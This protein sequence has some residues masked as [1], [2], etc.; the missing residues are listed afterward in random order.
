MT[1]A[2]TCFALALTVIAAAPA[3]ARTV[4][5]DIAGGTL[6]QSVAHLGRQ[7]RVSVGLADQVLAVRRVPALRG[8]MSVEDALARLLRGTGANALRID[9]F[10][11]RIVVP[12]PRRQPLPPFRRPAA[13]PPPETSTEEQEL[14]VVVGSRRDVPLADYPGSATIISGSDPDMAGAS[15]GTDAI[16][17][18]RADV[19]TTHLGPGRNKIFIRGMSESSINGISQATVGQ[20]FG[21]FRVNYNAPDPDLRMVD[22]RRVEI[23][24]GPQGTLY[25]AGTLGGILRVVPA[26]PEIDST[27]GMLQVGAT[28]TAHGDA[29][30]D[31]SASVNIPMGPR[32]A[33][34]ASAYRSQDGGYIDDI[35]RGIDDVNRVRTTGGR[36]AGRFLPNDDWTIDALLVKQRIRGDD[37]QYAESYFDPLERY[38]ALAQKFRND[39]SLS[40][41][42]ANYD[43]WKNDFSLSLSHS[44]QHL[45]ERYD[46]VP[47][48]DYP[49]VIAYDL[50]TRV[51]MFS[52]EARANGE[53]DRGWSWVVGAAAFANEARQER[54]VLIF[55]EASRRN[56]VSN[57]AFDVA[58]FG[59]VQ[60]PIS[61]IVSLTLG[62]RMMHVSSRGEGLVSQQGIGKGKPVLVEVK[63]GNLRA[64]PTVALSAKPRDDLLL[65]ARY[66]EGFRPGG[67][68]VSLSGVG[69]YDPDRV[70]V[71]EGGLRKGRPNGGP[72]DLQLA[73]GYVDWRDAQGDTLDV[74]AEQTTVNIGDARNLF[75]D[76]SLA[77]R[78][79][80]QLRVEGGVVLVDSEITSGPA[81]GLPLPGVAKLN[82][83]AAVTYGFTPFPNALATVGLSGRYTGRSYLDTGITSPG[84]EEFLRKKQGNWLDVALTGQIAVGRLTASL[85]V[86]N[87]FDSKANRFALGTPLLMAQRDFVTPLRPRTARLGLAYRFGVE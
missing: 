55:P 70:R 77:W 38:S 36:I 58:A 79:L 87:L 43:G 3:A 11:Y 81:R 37:S 60:F 31:G 63:R 30:Y 64:L 83:R 16:L 17:R 62:G 74:T 39:F 18:R 78:P 49:F 66:H 9:E 69:R 84:F 1:R 52:A 75:V 21:D 7:A 28:A 61:S 53:N 40:G 4:E 26:P 19:T 29:G 56:T 65:Y 13:P 67:L 42:S 71:F 51:K 47:A 15:R 12:P 22:I 33:V 20:Y 73:A 44:D 59:E 50:R 24:E 76:A 10:T 23:L 85:D 46:A 86:S 25:G 34:R 45:F 80:R 8:R 72:I 82:A 6:G 68:T 32:A 48:I 27:N 41:L 54:D 35:G 5:L 14:I 2:P 57:R